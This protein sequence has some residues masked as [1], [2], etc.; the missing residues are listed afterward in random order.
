MNQVYGR[1]LAVPFVFSLLLARPLLAPALAEQSSLDKVL[2]LVPSDVDALLIADGIA[3]E[4]ADLRQSAWWKNAEKLP[5]VQ[6]ALQSKPARNV[7]WMTAMMPAFLGVTL[8]QLRDDVLG[9][10]AVLALWKRDQK[11]PIGALIARASDAELLAKLIDTL[12]AERPGREVDQR[13]FRGQDYVETREA[14]GKKAYLFQRDDIGVIAGD[15]EAVR[16][17]IDTMLDGHGFGTSSIRA[18]L[19]RALPEQAFL[20]LY[21]N[22]RS[23]DHALDE[24]PPSND[25]FERFLLQRREAWDRVEWL[26]ATISSSPRYE[27]GLHFAIRS[28]KPP[29]PTSASLAAFWDRVDDSTLMAVHMMLPI[30]SVVGIVG[31]V[32][33]ERESREV[34]EAIRVISQFLA[35]YSV[36]DVLDHV[37]PSVGGMIAPGQPGQPPRVMGVVELRDEKPSTLGALPLSMALENSG[38]AVLVLIGVELSRKEKTPWRVELELSEG[39]RIHYLRR[40][41]APGSWPQPALAVTS[42][43]LLFGSS[44]KALAPW[45]GGEK[46]S[47]DLPAWFA[48]HFPAGFRPILWVNA[49]AVRTYLEREG[50][51]LLV[52]IT[53]D[54]PEHKER[55]AKRTGPIL[56]VMG[57]LD[58]LVIGVNVTSEAYHLTMT[59]FPTPAES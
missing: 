32:Q 3:D 26:A 11:D 52:L 9:E 45:L 46:E 12:S 6:Q 8:E 23:L 13:A 27:L 7:R 22:P 51:R 20:R 18:R 25:P 29:V 44:P 14:N 48:Q 50:D 36:P 53:R 55:L 19:R 43:Q 42:H 57:L 33:S 1:W 16:K 56:S 2:A 38:V 49:S 54:D 30:K 59:L 58:R 34:R 5:I 10:A 35:G 41:E 24:A 31:E 17:I 15:E 37:G 40:Q 28:M 39:E 4:Y 47:S 21:V